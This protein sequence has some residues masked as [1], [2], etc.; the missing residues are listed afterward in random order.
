MG[1]P[2]R[3]LFPE[4]SFFFPTQ[5]FCPGGSFFKFVEMFGFFTICY[6]CQLLHILMVLRMQ[7]NIPIL[8]KEIRNYNIVLAIFE[9]KHD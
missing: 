2:T 1:L 4:F 9:T 5:N 8:F 3:Q 6:F 7:K